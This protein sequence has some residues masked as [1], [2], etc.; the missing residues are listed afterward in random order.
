MKRPSGKE[1]GVCVFV[2][3]VLFHGVGSGRRASSASHS[4]RPYHYR[5]ARDRALSYRFSLALSAQ[6][7]GTPGVRLG[8]LGT[9][10]LIMTDGG[11]IPARRPSPRQRPFHAPL[12][13][14]AGRSFADMI[15]KSANLMQRALHNEA[16]IVR[17]ERKG[18]WPV[19]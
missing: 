2:G 5:G 19:E 7:K 15:Y 18:A 16:G 6:K 13:R 10:I 9:E 1:P 12:V 8:F 14:P 4:R 17:G 3:P 11:G